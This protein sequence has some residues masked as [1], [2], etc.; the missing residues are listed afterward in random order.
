MSYDTSKF[1]KALQE[2]NIELTEK[3]IEQF[4]KY[5]EML[6]ETNKVNMTLTTLRLVNVIISKRLTFLTMMLLLIRMVVSLK[7]WIVMKQE[8]RW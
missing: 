8:L 3:Q 4:M 6:V 1:E 2:L 7:E 5:Y